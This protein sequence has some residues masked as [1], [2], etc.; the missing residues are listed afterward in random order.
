MVR[1]LEGPSRVDTQII[2][3]LRKQWSVR[4]A[5]A[6]FESRELQRMMKEDKKDEKAHSHVPPDSW[7][8]PRGHA[9]G[10]VVNLFDGKRSRVAVEPGSPDGRR[11]YSGV[12]PAS[13]RKP[14]APRANVPALTRSRLVLIPW[15]RA[16]HQFCMHM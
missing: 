12:V 5:T 10:G 2:N 3:Y 6:E 7:V 14:R 16:S 15:S 9:N 13:A 1:K 4:L 8:D 11:L